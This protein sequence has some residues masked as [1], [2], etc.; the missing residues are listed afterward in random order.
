[1]NHES[2]TPIQPT[3]FAI[4]NAKHANMAF[5]RRQGNAIDM[6]KASVYNPEADNIKSGFAAADEDF[7]TYI[8]M[9]NVLMPPRVDSEAVEPIE[10]FASEAVWG[11][12]SPEQQA[13]ASELRKAIAGSELKEYGVTEDT[14]RVV[15]TAEENDGFKSFH[16]IHIGNGVDIGNPKEEFDQARSYNSVMSSANDALFQVEVNGAKYDTRRGMTAEVYDAKVADARQRGVT[17]TDSQP[18]S[19]ETDDVWTW[20]MLTGEKLTA[21]YVPVR[22]VSAGRV[23]RSACLPGRGIRLLRVCPAVEIQ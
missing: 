3:E 8:T 7:K 11:A 22:F 14:L 17:L 23:R 18:L 2:S 12:M 5:D 13:K 16:L 15:M 21:G 6:A 1:M 9:A 20:T 19:K 4:A 10:P